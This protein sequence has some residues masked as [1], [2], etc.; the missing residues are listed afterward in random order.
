MW[1]PPF[2][3]GG[4]PLL[5]TK[6]LGVEIPLRL[7]FEYPAVTAL[8]TAIEEILIEHL[9]TSPDTSLTG[10]WTSVQSALRVCRPPAVDPQHSICCYASF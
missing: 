6:M 4:A 3:L 2:S 9:E 8:A 10:L 1:Q 5:I 7:S